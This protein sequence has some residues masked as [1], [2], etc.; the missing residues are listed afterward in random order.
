MEEILLPSN[1]FLR[2]LACCLVEISRVSWMKRRLFLETCTPCWINNSVVFRMLNKMSCIG[3]LLS[4]KHSL[5]RRSVE[6]LPL[7]FPHVL[8]SKYCRPY[9]GVSCLRCRQMVFLCSSQ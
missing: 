7:P 2:L 6:A 4:A 1:L 8:F 5:S 9:M 3:L